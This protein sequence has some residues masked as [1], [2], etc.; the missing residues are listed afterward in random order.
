MGVDEEK[1]VGR[2]IY[3]NGLFDEIDC[4]LQIFLLCCV[5]TLPH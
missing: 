4:R 2:E 3:R 5:A 1:D